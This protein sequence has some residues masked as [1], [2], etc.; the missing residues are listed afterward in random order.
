MALTRQQSMTSTLS[1]PGTQVPGDEII[2]KNPDWNNPKQNVLSFRDQTYELSS[3]YIARSLI[4]I[5]CFLSPKVLSVFYSFLKKRF[6]TRTITNKYCISNK[7]KTQQREINSLLQS[8]VETTKFLYNKLYHRISTTLTMPDSDVP[9]LV[10]RIERKRPETFLNQEIP[11]LWDIIRLPNRLR[12]SIIR[13]IFQTKKYPRTDYRLETTLDYIAIQNAY[14]KL[15]DLAPRPITPIIVYRGWGGLTMEALLK[16]EFPLNSETSVTL[17]HSYASL[18]WDNSIRGPNESQGSKRDDSYPKFPDDENSTTLIRIKEGSHGII[19]LS[20]PD[21]EANDEIAE[22]AQEQR[23]ITFRKKGQYELVLDPRG[24]LFPTYRK[25]EPESL[26]NIPKN[27]VSY[28]EFLFEP[29][30]MLTSNTVYNSEVFN[31]KLAT[32]T[33]NCIYFKPLADTLCQVGN[34]SEAIFEN[35]G[36]GFFINNSGQFIRGEILKKEKSKWYVKPLPWQI[37]DQNEEVMYQKLGISRVDLNFISPNINKEEGIITW[38]RGKTQVENQEALDEIIRMSSSVDIHIPNNVSFSDMDVYSAPLATRNRENTVLVFNQDQLIQFED[39]E[40]IE[41]GGMVCFQKKLRAI[42]GSTGYTSVNE[43][44]YRLVIMRQFFPTNLP[45][46]RVK[47]NES[48]L[49]YF[50][51][52]KK[53][54]IIVDYK[55]ETAFNPSIPRPFEPFPPPRLQTRRSLRG[56]RKPPFFK[57]RAGRKTKKRRRNNKKSRK[58]KKK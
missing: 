19:N 46:A 56:S 36:I 4:S 34:Y 18:S 10:R 15:Y 1:I 48:R 24:V 8:P 58:Y 41:K 54:G 50:D 23:N 40:R 5:F 45:R 25:V 26:S 38:F 53:N 14:D 55:G 52:L 29:I 57:F 17:L 9:Q 2:S 6:S 44:S 28:D 22:V 7:T 13:E 33:N 39:Y 30:P 42:Y 11:R 31:E 21:E 16:G 3:M 51:Y 12:T 47:T 32:L 27:R 20:I 43:L 49:K 37:P 35:F